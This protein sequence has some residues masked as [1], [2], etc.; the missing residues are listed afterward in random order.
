MDALKGENIYMSDT[1][2]F[3]FWNSPELAIDQGSGQLP[4][5]QIMYLKHILSHIS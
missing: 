4:A 5:S 3:H 2:P 1:T